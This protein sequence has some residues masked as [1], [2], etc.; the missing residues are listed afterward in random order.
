MVQTGFGSVGSYAVMAKEP[1]QYFYTTDA[2]ATRRTLAEAFEET[3][4]FANVTFMETKDDTVYFDRRTGLVASPVQTY[5]ELVTGDKRRKKRPNR[6]AARSSRRST[7]GRV[8]PWTR[9]SRT[10]WTSSASST[11][12]GSRSRSAAVSV[13]I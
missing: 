6:S 3:D 11:P 9:C 4:R 8:K 5:L 13:C 1:M 2:A 7:R 12:A 10:S